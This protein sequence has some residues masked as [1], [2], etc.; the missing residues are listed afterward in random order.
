[1]PLQASQSIEVKRVSGKG[2]GVFAREKIPAGTVFERVPVIVMPTEDIVESTD[3]CVLA[4]YVFDWGKGTVALALGF[5]SLYNH[6][7]NPNARYDDEGRQTKI[8]TALRDIEP[9]EEIT[10]NYN[11]HEDDQSP[12]GFDVLESNKATSAK[13]DSSAVSNYLPNFDLVSSGVE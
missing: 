5:G 7:Y 9:G 2:R 4:N 3:K 11:G 6:S 12:V 10:V 8:F 1:M 13:P